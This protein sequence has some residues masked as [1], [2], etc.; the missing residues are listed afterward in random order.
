ADH[1][2]PWWAVPATCVAAHVCDP[3]DGLVERGRLADLH[4]LWLSERDDGV[5]LVA[6]ELVRCRSVGRCSSLM[7][8]MHRSCCHGRQD[9][10]PFEGRLP[11]SQLRI[12]DSAK[13]S[14]PGSME[15]FDA[16]AERVTGNDGADVGSSVDGMRREQQPLNAVL[17]SSMALA[18]PNGIEVDS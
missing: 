14:L 8:Q 11:R 4:A 9:S 5:D 10:R 13:P 1:F 15:V 18:H 6:R 17:I 7:S 3:S 2:R 16:P 12:F